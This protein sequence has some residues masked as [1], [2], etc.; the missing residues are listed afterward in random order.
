MRCVDRR[1]TFFP[2]V[3][4]FAVLLLA[5]RWAGPSDAQAEFLRGFADLPLMPGLAEQADAAV[6]FDSP[7]GRIAEAVAAGA[8]GREVVLGFYAE[9]LPAL[10]WRQ[11]GP[12]RFE[13]E[14]EVLE[15]RFANEDRRLV[16]RFSLAPPGR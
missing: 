5:L 14:G 12:A 15:L 7:Y 6:S 11:T 3:V 2:G 1:H 8:V 4:L 13:R 9:T 10:G 16:V